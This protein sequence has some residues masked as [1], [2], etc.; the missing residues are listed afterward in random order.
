MAPLPLTRPGGHQVVPVVPAVG[1]P[2][3]EA[4]AAEPR[5]AV[6]AVLRLRVVLSEAV[7]AVCRWVGRL[8]VLGARVPSA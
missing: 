5:L 3:V 7:A 2:E 6:L 8:A 4:V 1:L